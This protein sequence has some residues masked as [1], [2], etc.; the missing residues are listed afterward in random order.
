MPITMQR[1]GPIH[2]GLPVICR[3]AMMAGFV[4]NVLASPLIHLHFPRYSRNV[5]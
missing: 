5:R 1:I 3:A 2:V 4:K